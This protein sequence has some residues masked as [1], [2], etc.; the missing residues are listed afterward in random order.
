MAEDEARRPGGSRRSR[1]LFDAQG[2]ITDDPAAAVSGEVVERSPTGV[3]L[4]R[5]KFFLERDHLP[6]LPVGEAAFLLW[7]LGGLV[8][9]W[10]IVAVVL[11]IS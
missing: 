4:R 9:V 10:V 8:G 7:V 2:H 6:W 5:R 1:V 11:R 3:V